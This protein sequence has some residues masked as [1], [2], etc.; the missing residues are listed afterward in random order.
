MC[1]SEGRDLVEQQ[2]DYYAKLLS[3]ARFLGQLLH[4]IRNLE[5]MK[6]L[7]NGG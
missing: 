1:R 4:S 6:Y 7:F 5:V 2:T 3:L